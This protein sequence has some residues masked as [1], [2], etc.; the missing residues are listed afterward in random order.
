MEN[1]FWCLNTIKCKGHM[2][3]GGYL[4]TC[5][6]IVVSPD[7]TSGEQPLVFGYH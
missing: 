5:N 2:G 4:R 1:N 3:G 7:R 6:K